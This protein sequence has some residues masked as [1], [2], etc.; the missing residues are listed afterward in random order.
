MKTGFFPVWENYTR[1]P[2]TGPVQGC[3]AVRFEVGALV[4]LILDAEYLL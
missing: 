1:R 2:C 4:A 3:S